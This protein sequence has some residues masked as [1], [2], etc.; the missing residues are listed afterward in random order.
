MCRSPPTGSRAF[1]D[2]APHNPVRRSFAVFVS[3]AFRREYAELANLRRR[4]TSPLPLN[5][6]L[7]L[8]SL[9]YV[10]R[11]SGPAFPEPDVLLPPPREG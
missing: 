7:K 1:R 2:D 10:D 4:H 9:G 5:V 3:Q 6:R 8:E 11:A